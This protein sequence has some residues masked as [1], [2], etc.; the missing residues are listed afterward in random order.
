MMR[1]ILMGGAA[2]ALMAGAASA[3]GPSRLTV[4][5]QAELRIAPDMAVI[6]LGVSSQAANAADAMHQTSDLQ[7]A[8]IKALND[9]GVD[10]ANIQTSGLTLNPVMTYQDGQAPKVTG[11]QAVNRV[12]VRVVDLERLGPVIDAVVTAGANEINGISFVRDDSADSLDQARAD[13]VADARRKAMVLAQAAGVELGPV[14]SL[15]ESSYGGG[16]QPM[17]MRQMAMDAT[18]APVQAG[19]L[20]LTAQVDMEYALTGDGACSAN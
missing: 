3:C 15:R 1:Q 4:S 8:V 2:V 11:Y 9:G 16:P 18:A 20:S 5:G 10:D 13:A 12:S 17:M 7:S 14:I 19:Q 6:D